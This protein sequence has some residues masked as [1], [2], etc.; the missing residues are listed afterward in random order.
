[1]NFRYRIIFRGEMVLFYP[2]NRNAFLLLNGSFEPYI[3]S[4]HCFLQY[5][6]ETRCFV[7]F[8]GTKPPII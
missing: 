2:A 5:E 8:M 1:M 6:G 3:Y 7:T 4:P